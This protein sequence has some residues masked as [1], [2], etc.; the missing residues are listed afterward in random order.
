[1]MKNKKVIFMGTPEFSVPVLQMLIDNTDV[2]MV[3]T[4]PD[5]EVGRNKD[6]IFSPIKALAI[7]NNIPVFQ[8]IKIR[9]NY[10]EVI[11][12]NPDIV[13]TCAYGQII[14]ESILNA[15][16]YG[17][18]NVHA[19]L[20][21]AL[22]GGAPIHHAILDGYDE[23]GVT[24]MYMDKGMDTGNIISQVRTKIEDTD[25]VGTL[26]DR[27]SI[28]GSKLLK[29][30]LPSIFEGTNPSIPQDET[31][32]T[33]GYNIKR[34]EE[35]ID[36]N[37]SSREVFNKIRGLYHSPT[38]YAVLDGE[39]IKILESRVGDS[40]KG[41]PGEIINI[42]KDS[43]GVMCKDTEI[44]ITRVKPEGKKEMNAKDFINGRKDLLGKVFNN[45]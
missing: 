12:A 35:L 5:K 3:V 30:T 13:V 4:Q 44:V 17:C 22:R 31:E 7:E 14:P 43:F 21:P 25:N 38:S 27:L 2:I 11:D 34:E 39:I 9:E 32:V 16:K 1:M 37:M 15:P 23:T 10:K 45:D 19:S 29:S 24:I 26:H 42:Y 40:S 18:I 20:L 6:I 36:F 8:P 28:M 41:I 33:Y